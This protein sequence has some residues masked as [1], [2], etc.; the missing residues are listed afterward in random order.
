[1]GLVQPAAIVV[2]RAVDTLLDVLDR[3]GHVVRA[4][5]ESELDELDVDRPAPAVRCRIGAGVLLEELEPLLWRPGRDGDH[6]LHPVTGGGG[7][8]PVD[9]GEARGTE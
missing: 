6:P 1:M 4:A 2:V 9:I 3:A 7:A 5:A 8:G